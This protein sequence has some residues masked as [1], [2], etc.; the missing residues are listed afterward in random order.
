MLALI[1]KGGSSVVTAAVRHH[2]VAAP[3]DEYATF[4]T[5]TIVDDRGWRDASFPDSL[6]L[7]CDDLVAAA[8]QD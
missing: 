1:N 6:D 7:E 2:E 3:E 4:D 5:R 8:F